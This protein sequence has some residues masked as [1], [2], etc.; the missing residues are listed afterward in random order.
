MPNSITKELLQQ[1]EVI[2]DL[3]SEI[4]L[5]SRASST[6]D[7]YVVSLQHKLESELNTF[8]DIYYEYYMIT[9]DYGGFDKRRLRHDKKFMTFLS[10]YLPDIYNDIEYPVYGGKHKPSHLKSSR[11]SKRK[12]MVSKKS[13][14]KNKKSTR[15]TKKPIRKGK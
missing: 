5:F 14:R 6:E 4:E 1:Y 8:R 12:V 11:K 2:K 15:K 3:I 7:P 13:T 10:E 9:E